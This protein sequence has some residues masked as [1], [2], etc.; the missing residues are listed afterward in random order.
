[1][2]PL[3][4]LIFD[5]DDTLIDS[6]SIYKRV[7]KSLGLGPALHFART[8]AKNLAGE[9]NPS[10]HNRLIYFKHLTM[11]QNSGSAKD[12]LSL[13]NRYEAALQKEVAK[14]LKVSKVIKTLSKLRKH[15][16]LV[17]FTNETLR[18]QLIKLQE[19]DP[20]GQIFDLILTSEEIG[21]GNG[22]AFN[23]Q[24]TDLFSNLKGPVKDFFSLLSG[25]DFR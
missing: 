25:F 6:E 14:D 10:R 1:M 3:R 21:Q 11:N 17:I 24:I 9:K 8:S 15:F 4:W 18:T 13:M 5:L 19:I 16:H 20:K 12:T 23:F 7:Y 22:P 2:R